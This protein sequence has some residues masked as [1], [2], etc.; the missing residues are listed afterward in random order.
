[1]TGGDKKYR[2][3]PSAGFIGFRVVAVKLGAKYSFRRK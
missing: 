3:Q 2:E 1:M